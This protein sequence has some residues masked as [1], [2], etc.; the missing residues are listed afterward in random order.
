MRPKLTPIPK[1]IA[2]NGL[3]KKERI[4]ASSASALLKKG[5]RKTPPS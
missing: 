1:P 3:M 2:V 5:N 4:E